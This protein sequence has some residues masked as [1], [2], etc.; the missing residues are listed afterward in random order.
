MVPPRA[1]IE[2]VHV[3]SAAARAAAVKARMA[4]AEARAVAL[5]VRL[6]SVEASSEATSSPGQVAPSSP[7]ARQENKICRSGQESPTSRIRS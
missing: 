6:T 2:E 4:A 7:A 1:T 3:A 5:E